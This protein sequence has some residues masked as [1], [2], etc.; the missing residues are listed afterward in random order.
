WRRALLGTSPSGAF[1]FLGG[2][3]G[4]GRCPLSR[5]VPPETAPRATASGS[6]EVLA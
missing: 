1:S 2:W 4:S 3:R 6:P 5:K